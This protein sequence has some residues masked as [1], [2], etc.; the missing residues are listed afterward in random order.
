MP[1]AEATENQ[2]KKIREISIV[3]D[4]LFFE[5]ILVGFLEAVVCW[6]HEIA[7][8]LVLSVFRVV[9]CL[10]VNGFV[11]SRREPG[12]PALLL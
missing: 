5:N 1:K 3:R 7:R 2:V 6:S 9:F 11:W 12:S 8:M 4:M 10:F